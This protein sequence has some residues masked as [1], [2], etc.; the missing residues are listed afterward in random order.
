MPP[1]EAGIL[2]LL[3]A[4]HEVI[5][6]Q[7]VDTQVAALALALR[8]VCRDGGMPIE[9]AIELV[10]SLENPAYTLPEPPVCAVCDADSGDQHQAWRVKQC[11]CRFCIC[12]RC[13]G[14]IAASSTDLRSVAFQLARFHARDCT[15]CRESTPERPN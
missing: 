6:G 2:D 1:W 4:V 8:Q 3:R 5:G 15:R 9:A 14:I 11:G 13:R 10:K 12:H 7:D